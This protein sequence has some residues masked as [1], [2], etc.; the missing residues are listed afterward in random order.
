MIEQLLAIDRNT[1]F[2]S[3]RQ[4]IVLVVLIIA[5]VFLILSN[6]LA[7]FTMED[8]QRMLIDI[9]MATVFLS[10]TLLAAF[11][12]TGVLTREI[13][14]KTALTVISKPVGRPVFVI[15]K[16][17]GVAALTQHHCDRSIWIHA[18]PTDVL[19]GGSGHHVL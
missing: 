2:E 13:E 1:F 10:G 11:V 16:F 6:P 4:P 3:I 7:A 14:N 9:G 12:A 19:R 18:Q 5:S 17:L 8:D 15:G